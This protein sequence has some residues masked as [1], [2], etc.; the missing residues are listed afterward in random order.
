MRVVHIS[1]AH[2][3]QPE[4]T[5]SVNVWMQ[6]EHHSRFPTPGATV[7]VFMQ[8]EKNLLLI[9]L[10]EGKSFL[11]VR[12][13]ALNVRPN[14]TLWDLVPE[15]LLLEIYTFQLLWGRWC[16]H[17]LKPGR[18]QEDESL[19]ET[20]L[21]AKVSRNYLLR[22]KTKHLGPNHCT[23]VALTSFKYNQFR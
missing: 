9:T 8:L 16:R 5:G 14:L 21:A 6:K 1:L 10:R 13:W 12:K 22:R 4:S 7:S 17:G 23:Q 18:K 11:K 3:S 2:R 19:E 20:L 15:V